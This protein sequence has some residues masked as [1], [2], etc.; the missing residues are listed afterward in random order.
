MYIFNEAN[1]PLQI[2]QNWTHGIAYLVHNLNSNTKFMVM[3][4]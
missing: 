2:P 4:N 3:I 1:I